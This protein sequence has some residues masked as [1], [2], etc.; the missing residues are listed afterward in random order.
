[1]PQH[2]TTATEAWWWWAVIKLDPCL[3]NNTCKVWHVRLVVCTRNM[4]RCA[5]V[6]PRY[7]KAQLYLHNKKSALNLPFHWIKFRYQSFWYDSRQQAATF[8]KGASCLALNSKQNTSDPR[9]NYIKILVK[10]QSISRCQI[11]YTK[12]L[13]PKV[14]SPFLLL[15]RRSCFKFTFYGWNMVWS[16]TVKQKYNANHESK[17]CKFSSSH[18]RKLIILTYNQHGKMEII[19]HSYF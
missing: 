17:S 4:A 13:I 19:F 8:T 5:T 18:I 16:S 11:C 6:H 9:S 7:I 12:F 14:F 10:L 3:T 1:M 2:Y 15:A